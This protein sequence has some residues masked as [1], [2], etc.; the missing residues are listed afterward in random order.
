MNVSSWSIRNP[1]PAVMLFVLLTLAGAW[2]FKSMKV[3][4]LPDMDLP[5]VTV[6]AMLPGA[7]PGQLETDVARKIEN[8]IAT[9]QGLKHIHTSI[10]DGVATIT[11]EFR[12]EKPIQEAVDDVRSAVNRVRADMPADLR[13]PIIT[14]VDLAGTPVLAFTIQSSQLD[15]EGLSWFV[16]DTV[17]RKLLTVPGVGAVNRV[18]GVQREVR[19][20]LDAQRLQALGATAAEVSRQLRQVQNESAGGRTN[21]GD[22]EQPVRTLATVQSAEEL[23]NLQLS[24][25]GRRIRLADLATVTDT[26][27]EKRSAALLNGQSV[28]G[29]E[30]SRS[31]G[32]SE[33]EVGAAVEQA[34][35]QLKAQHPDI[36]LTEA[37]DFV[38]PVSEEYASSLHL[39]Y[40]GAILAVVVV[41]FFLRDW[42]ATFVSAVALPLSVIPAFAGMYFL[43][44]SVNGI[45]LLALSLVIG[46]LV[47]D[48]IVEVENIVRHLRMGKSPYQ[49]AMEA[50]D[51]IGL[52]VVATTFTL[53]AVF[54]PTAF[55]SGIAGRFFKQFGWTAAL[56]VF[57]SLVVA[58][59]L[60]PMMAAY[61]L[62][63]IVTAEHEPRWMRIYMVCANWSLRHRL[64]TMALATLFFFGSLALIPLLPTGFIPPD[65]N[66]QTQVY[67]ELP[68]GS[69]LQQTM[70]VAE[71]ARLRIMALEH[72]KSIYTTI[73]GGSAGSDPFAGSG[74]AEPRR[75]TLTVQLAP[76]SER[77]RK[78]GIEEHIRNTLETLPGVRLKVGLAGGNNKYVLVLS[79]DDP[80]ALSEAARAVE[81][82]LRTVPGF[83]NIA[84]SASLV[85][86]EIAVRP[87]FARAADLGVTSAAIGETLRIATMGD[88]DVSLPKLNLAQRQ[89][90]IVVRLG[91]AARE[92]LDTLRRLA[93][94]GTHGP[95]MLGEVATLEVAGGPAVISRYDRARNVNFDIELSSVQL[96][97][98][99][100]VVHALPAVQNLPSGVRVTEVGDAE[101]MGEL[102]ASFGLAMLTGVLCIY[103]VLVLLFKD[104]LHPVTILAALPLSLGGAFVG[105]LIAQKSFSMPS[106]IG[107]IMLMGIATK[108][109]ILL[110][111][112]AIL[113]R[114]E[115]GMTRLQAL[116]DA[117]H[118]R[119][120]PIIMTTIAMG[121]GML[122]I[123]VGFGAADPSFRSPMAVAV[124]GGLITSTVLSLLVIPAVFTY[125]DDLGQWVMR[126]LRRR[127]VA[128]EVP[129]PHRA[130]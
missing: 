102:F 128:A 23:G 50:A 1:I 48:A 62:K 122:P 60:T 71:E 120:R 72:I 16:D 55:M 119:A 112:Y 5:M 35:A 103:I 100:K 32:A 73:G 108:N 114:R 87:D 37:F 18:G 68:P 52:A 90:P 40:E 22:G 127:P 64:A 77:P 3:Q 11:A 109:S 6:T 57:A 17:A 45:T 54:L 27:A 10:Q 115:H 51:E 81:R 7:A 93:V 31:R 15:E 24:I 89:V 88:Y 58:R 129:E 99:A 116:L 130:E 53:I 29:F 21:L 82:E 66:S 125:V 113:A 85:R 117:C 124:I 101:V 74:G 121:A 91:D 14:K 92:D 19:V 61:L 12:L 118:K 79:G 20:A 4:N 97:D 78:L 13:D 84:S 49:A 36:T 30:V 123:A 41:W 67:L 107:L 42:R 39:L 25:G 8:S 70:A 9:V 80:Q 95:V 38:T 28:V 46:I 75:A 69:N 86:P 83:G 2:S 96:G 43:G 110:V 59:V 44:F 94:P 56:A 106:L 47:D 65:D 34:L 76:R 105:L 126:K 104:F 26:V 98:A 63:P 111:E 33:V